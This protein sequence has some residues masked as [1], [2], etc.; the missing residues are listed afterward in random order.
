LDADQVFSIMFS[1]LAF[2]FLLFYVAV[3]MTQPHNRFLFLYP[4]KLAQLCFILGAGFH[5][6]SVMNEEKPL[7]RLGPATILCLILMPWGL[8]AQYYGPLVTDT[9]WNGMIDQIIKSGLA[10]ILLEATALNIY[11]IWAVYA[12]ILISTLWWLKAGMRLGAAGAT[13]SGDRIMGPAVSMV[14]NPN[15]Y[16]YFTCV[17]ILVYLYFYQQHPKKLFRYAFLGMALVSVW[18]VLQTGS[19]SGFLVLI[20]AGLFVLPK[21]GG[22]YKVALLVAAVASPLLLGTV[23]AMNI[24]RFKTIPDSIRSFL[25]GE[26]LNLDQAAA[27]GA[28]AHS[29]VERKLKNRDTWR[30]IR[31]YPI[32]G[33]GMKANDGLYADDETYARGMVHNELLQA[34]RQMG[35][36]GMAMYLAMITILFNRG[37]KVERY[38]RGWWP[39]MADLGWTMKLQAMII[40]VGGQF[41]V[42]PW[43]TYTMVLMASASAL[44]MNLQEGRLSVDGEAGLPV[45]AG[46]A[47]A[48][49]AETPSVAPQA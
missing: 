20:A 7:I 11:R 35:F 42:L 45:T 39:A 27:E 47:K 21:Y 48:P 24:E 13:I 14:E 34:G 18:I 9:S 28:D 1:R 33:T 25:S 2:L 41:N 10:V 17:T 22:K 4:F 46:P 12:T 31:R 30:V 40:F 23:G 29:A 44:W 26:Q 8:I 36:P 43:N 15:A 19:R 16:A 37:L 49:A 5:L 6:L 3:G 32:I 38:A